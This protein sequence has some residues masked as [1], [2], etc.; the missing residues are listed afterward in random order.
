MMKFRLMMEVRGKVVVFSW[1][2][3]KVNESQ[4]KQYGITPHVST[5]QNLLKENIKKR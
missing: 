4:Y 3:L 1:V 5:G 2:I